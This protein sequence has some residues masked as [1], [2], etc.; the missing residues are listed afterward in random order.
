MEK[1]P[2]LAL[3]DASRADFCFVWFARVSSLKGSRNQRLRR[4]PRR[5]L[6]C[7]GLIQRT[8]VRDPRAATSLLLL[9][10]IR[11]FPSITRRHRRLQS[12]YFGRWILGSLIFRT[13]PKSAPEAFMAPSY[14]FTLSKHRKITKTKSQ[15]SYVFQWFYPKWNPQIARN[16]AW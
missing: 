2:K 16:S 1:Y 10:F 15:F 13:T 6:D 12:W 8:T 11:S 4:W 14:G 9:F 3:V 5:V 7:L